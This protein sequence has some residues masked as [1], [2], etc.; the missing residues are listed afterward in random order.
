MS[1]HGPLWAVDLVSPKLSCYENIKVLRL[2]RPADVKRK[3]LGSRAG[4]PVGQR[5]YIQ[6]HSNSKITD[7]PFEVIQGCQTILN[8][9]T[10][11]TIPCILL[12]YLYIIL[13]IHSNKVTTD[14][15]VKLGYRVLTRPHCS[16]K[17]QA[18]N[19]L[20]GLGAN[21]GNLLRQKLDA[22]SKPTCI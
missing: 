19:G 4:M 2:F 21:C 5:N 9:L 16:C 13:R 10:L 18:T 12:T 11:G 1:Y 6:I 7:Q 8:H 3:L 17:R 15:Q 20:G 14:G 22:I